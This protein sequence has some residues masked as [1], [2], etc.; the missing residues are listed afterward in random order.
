MAPALQSHPPSPYAPP[1]PEHAAAAAGAACGAAAGRPSG[2]GAAPRSRP[3]APPTTQQSNLLPPCKRPSPEHGAAAE[4]RGARAGRPSDFAPWPRPPAPPAPQ[5]SPPRLGGGVPWWGTP[6]GA[7]G[8]GRGGL[9]RNGRGASAADWSA[10]LA[11]AAGPLAGSGGGGGGVP[12]AAPHRLPPSLA[13]ES[14]EASFDDPTPGGSGGGQVGRHTAAPGLG[15]GGRQGAGAADAGGSGPSGGSVA[16]FEDQTLTC[17]E[18]GDGF[19]FP[20]KKQEQYAFKRFKAPGLC[21]DCRNERYARPATGDGTGGGADGRSNG[22]GGYRAC[23]ICHVEGHVARDCPKP[24][25]ERIA[26]KYFFSKGW[27]KHGDACNFRHAN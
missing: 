8:D 1:A 12:G 7:A 13:A 20:A 23:F 27:C 16:G 4:E 15:L 14:I 21:R 18:C 10:G 22:R 5:Q 11:V 6:G 24:P 2:F 17:R 9:E 25:S 3:P 26:C 19:V